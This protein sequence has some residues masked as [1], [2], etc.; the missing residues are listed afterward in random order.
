VNICFLGQ[1]CFVALFLL[2][3]NHNK[4]IPII[5]L[6]LM[7]HSKAMEKLMKNSPQW[8][9]FGAEVRSKIHLVAGMAAAHMAPATSI[10][11]TSDLELPPRSHFFP[12]HPRNV[13]HENPRC[14]ANPAGNISWQLL[15]VECDDHWLC[16]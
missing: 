1:I 15:H 8:W 4:A 11:F 12:N 16:P 7:R 6:V 10:I 2:W 14:C 9:T 5:T 13:H 3:V